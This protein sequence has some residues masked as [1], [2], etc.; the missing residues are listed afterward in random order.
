MKFIDPDLVSTLVFL[1]VCAGIIAA[2]AVAVWRTKGLATMIKAVMI[3][4][5]LLLLMAAIVS[6]GFLEE[7][8]FPRLPLFFASNLLIAAAF[9]FTRFAGSLAHNL[10]FSA[11]FGFLGF[12]VPLELVLHSWVIE[13]VIPETM[14]WTGQNWDILSGVVAIAAASWFPKNKP[15]AWAA[16]TIG[17]VLLLNVMRVA[18]FS[19]PLP[20]AWNVN[21]PLQ[22]AFHLPYALILPLCVGGA[23]VGHILITRKLLSVA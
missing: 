13:G 4:A 1:G 22:L 19:S 6:S 8:P 11:L 9:A 5:V 16:N 23:L 15:L 7:A 21:P 10:S 14:T 2:F 18:V 3:L 12:R 20:F 17:F